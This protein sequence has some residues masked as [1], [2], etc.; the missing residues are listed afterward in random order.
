MLD[1][2][3]LPEWFLEV[4]VGDFLVLDV[5]VVED[6]LIE[7]APLL[8]G[9][10]PVQ[11]LGAF[12]QCQAHVDQAGGIGEVGGGG[13]AA[14]GEVTP[15]AFDVA[16]L[17]FDLGLRQGAV[18]GEVDH[19][20]LLGVEFVELAGELLMQQSRGFLLFVDDGVDLGADVGDE[21]LA[22][23]DRGVVPFDG[24]LDEFGVDVR[25]VAGAGLAATA[26]EVQVLGAL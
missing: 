7:Q 23:A 2:V 15:L 3:E 26:E 20:L 13:I 4:V 14:L 11:L 18:G 5:D 9:A 16:E 21:R 12:E 1:G 22:E 10:P 24:V 8:L 17:G 19:V 6:R 25:G